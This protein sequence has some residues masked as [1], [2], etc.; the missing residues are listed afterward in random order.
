MPD[1]FSDLAKMMRSNIPASNMPA[2]INIPIG[3]KVIT[4][5]CNIPVRLTVLD[6]WYTPA[7]SQP[8]VPSQKRGRP[9]CSKDS[10]SRKRENLAQMNSSE[11]A[12]STDPS[13]DIIPNY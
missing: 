9:L 8:C 1:A 5:G 4:E 11:I 3:C 6:E 12:I 2:R 7:A 10:H 13:Y